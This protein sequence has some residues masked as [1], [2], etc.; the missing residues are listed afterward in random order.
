MPDLDAVSIGP[1]NVD[2][3][4]TE[5]RMSIPSVARTYAY[6]LDVLKNL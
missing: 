5:E 6:L 3:H 2:I 4:T 1:D